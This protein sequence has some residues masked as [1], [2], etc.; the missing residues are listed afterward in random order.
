MATFAYWIMGSI[1]SVDGEESDKMSEV[2]SPLFTDLLMGL[3]PRS[4]SYQLERAPNPADG[5]NGL[6]FQYTVHLKKKMRLATFANKVKRALGEPSRSVKAMHCNARNHKY[7]TKEDTRVQGPWEYSEEEG[8]NG[9]TM[10]QLRAL[11]LESYD[12]VE[13]KDWQRAIIDLV[14]QD[15]H[16]RRVY[17][18][19]EPHGNV[20][21]SY[22]IKYLCAK[23]PKEV[24]L[25]GGTAKHIRH[26]VGK[27]PQAKCIIWDVPRSMVD[28]QSTVHWAVL[29]EIKNGC[30]FS[31]FGL[32]AC[33][34]VRPPPHVMIF[35]NRVP[36][37]AELSEDRWFTTK[38]HC[39]QSVADFIDHVYSE[40]D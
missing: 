18:F 33:M 35:S 39:L 38:L 21:K 40:D 1:H 13:W 29:E 16:P 8:S 6:H 32:D 4:Y 5:R 28:K 30:W 24:M 14:D 17:C 37:L 22:L 23:Y 25:V 11:V 27:C 36:P 10:E 34:H 31:D 3:E 12:S 20:G 15:P 19:Y 9:S 26:A 2:L 7:S